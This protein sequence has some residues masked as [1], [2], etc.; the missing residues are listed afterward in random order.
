MSG[1]PLLLA[2]SLDVVSAVALAG[3]RGVLTGF[4]LL[5]ERTFTHLASLPLG[6]A[7]LSPPGLDLRPELGFV[8]AS[9]PSDC[10]PRL[11]G[12]P[13]PRC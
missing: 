5:G 8:G 6:P 4:V 7:L 1:S 11:W 3:A 12:A 10:W 2:A 9:G 13:H